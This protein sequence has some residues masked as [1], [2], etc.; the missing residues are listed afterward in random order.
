M[1]L[2][3][4][5]YRG[6][7]PFHNLGVFNDF[8]E[9]SDPGDLTKGDVLVVWGGGDIHPSL[10]NKPVSK[11]SWVGAGPSQRDI[12][13]WSMMQRAKELGLHIIGV[14]RGGQMLCALA[15]GHLIQH[16]SGHSGMH[17]VVTHE[18]QKLTTNS[19]H[20]QMMVPDGTEHE[21]LAQIPSDQLL[22]HEYW[23]GDEK[24]DHHS[25]PEF[26]YFNGVRG[27]AIQWHPEMM[28]ED[29]VAT[30][31]VLREIGARIHA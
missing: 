13:E 17:Q 23:D 14:C 7:Y 19:I 29:S 1:R 26:I 27:H 8:I 16:V 5:Y 10:Y 25:E 6:I 24:V 31:F 30:K 28:D 21:V 11:K 12:V 18:G 4:A 20:H 15:G 9:S 3:S 2:V 22:S